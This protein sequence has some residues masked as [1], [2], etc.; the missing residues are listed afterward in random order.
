MT[1]R[2]SNLS[3]RDLLV[4]VSSFQ[5]FPPVFQSLTA[6]HNITIKMMDVFKPITRASPLP[7]PLLCYFHA[8]IDGKHLVLEVGFG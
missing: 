8:V 5:G 1:Q 3:N 2:I 6:A 7:L 4:P